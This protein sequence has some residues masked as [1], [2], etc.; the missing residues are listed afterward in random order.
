MTLPFGVAIYPDRGK[1]TLDP[2]PNI[3]LTRTYHES[4]AGRIELDNGRLLQLEPK[5]RRY[6]R[7]RERDDRMPEARSLRGAPGRETASVRRRPTTVR[8]DLADA[9]M[10]AVLERRHSVARSNLAR[11]IGVSPRELHL[12]ELGCVQPESLPAIA[13]FFGIDIRSRIN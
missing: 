5:R 1:S 3:K 4:A 6:D 9:V 12:A 10:V 11:T 13:A 2:L 7:V 8:R